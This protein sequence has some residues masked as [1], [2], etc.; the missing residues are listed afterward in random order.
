MDELLIKEYKIPITADR[1][2]PKKRLTKKY[3]VPEMCFSDIPRRSFI[4]KYSLF[5]NGYIVALKNRERLCYKLLFIISRL[6]YPNGI[7]R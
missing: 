4:Y 7:A 3:F 1:I 5:N 2:I 6:G